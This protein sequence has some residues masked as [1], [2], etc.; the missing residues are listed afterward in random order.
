MPD[1][2]PSLPGIDVSITRVVVTGAESTGK[3]TLA[4]RLARRFGTAWAPEYLRS[5]VQQKKA[6]PEEFDAWNIARG[7]LAQEQE[8][9]RKASGVLFLDT[10]L[11]LTCIYQSFYFGRCPEW[12]GK[13]S[14]ERA[15]DL[16]VV[17]NTDIPW[18]SDPG[19]R[20]GPHVRAAV[21]ARLLAELQARSLPFLL[22]SGTLDERTQQAARAVDALLGR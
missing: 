3:T 5:F 14:A 8:L 11:I 10:D 4:R 13:A 17:T 16:Y 6:P 1:K 20:D 15:A 21:H 7:H 22:V 18:K 2:R 12:L 9:A 19:Q